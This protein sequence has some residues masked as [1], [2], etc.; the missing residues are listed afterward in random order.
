MRSH[1]HRMI[2][3][4]ARDRGLPGN[5]IWKRVNR[6]TG[7]PMNAIAFAVTV[8]FLLG[9]PLIHSTV[10]FTAVV[11]ISTIGLYIS[12][13]IPIFC[14][15][16]IG[17]KNFQPGPFNLG[18][19]SQPIGWIAVFWVLFITVS[20]SSVHRQI[21]QYKLLCPDWMHQEEQGRVVVLLYH[22]AVSHEGRSKSEAA[23]LANAYQ[24]SASAEC[25]ALPP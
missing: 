23:S 16:T 18:F 4:F 13:G 12:Y 7:T 24:T 21:R 10:A 9:L 6:L 2:W 22:W 15:L 14:R 19:L 1:A 20:P 17:R 11:S 25:C 8:A 5:V 3:S